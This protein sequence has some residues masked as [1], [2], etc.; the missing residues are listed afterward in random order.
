MRERHT[1]KKGRRSVP[2][3]SLPRMR[4]YGR[5]SIFK[6]NPLEHRLCHKH[7]IMQTLAAMLKTITAGAMLAVAGVADMDLCEF[8]QHAVTVEFA[9]R[10]AAGN[11]VVDIVF[12]DLLLIP[13]YAACI[14][15]ISKEDIDKSRKSLYN[16]EKGEENHESYLKARRQGQRQKG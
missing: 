2:S 14:Q 8:A 10:Y 11:A 5:D 9:F 4:V 7:A 3:A 13:Q 6:A 16:E 1:C 12:H 15:K